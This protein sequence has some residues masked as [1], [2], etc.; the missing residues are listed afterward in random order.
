[1]KR[2]IFVATIAFLLAACGG[3]EPEAPPPVAVTV[4]GLDTFQFTPATLSLPAGAQVDLTFKNGGGL[5]HNFVLV[6]QNVDPLSVTEADALGG[7]N[8]GTV[9]A[10]GEKNFTFTAPAAGTY[11]YV[12]TIAGHAAGGMVGTL[13][14]TNP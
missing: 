3:S 4:E 1:M 10:G 6:G 9:A 12:C 11:Q 8:A 14:T 2:L 13:T 7:V 5:D